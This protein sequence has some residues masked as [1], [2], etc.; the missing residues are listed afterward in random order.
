M[1]TNNLQKQIAFIKEIDKIKYIQRRSK[2]FNSDRRE[3]DAEHSWHLAMMAIVLAEHSNNSIDLL[4]V[5]KMVLIHDIVEIDAG[6]TFIYDTTKKHANIDEEHIA[7]KRIFG[8]LPQEQAE[9][10]LALW[11]EFEEG[12]TD[13]AKFAKTMDRFEPLLQD[14]TNDGG[15]WMEFDVP[16]QNVYDMNKSI[17]KGSTTIWNYADNLINESVGKGFLKK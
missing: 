4:K 12:E 10:L 8:L 16:Y 7:A 17:K 11:E 9:E 14:A 5:L 2:L 3:N 1:Q 13:E 15:T 6:D